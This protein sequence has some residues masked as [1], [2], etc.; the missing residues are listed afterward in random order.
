MDKT[1]PVPKRHYS[2]A[3]IVYRQL[4]AYF[5]EKMFHVGDRVPPERALADA[6]KANR[7][8][9]RTAMQRM[10][11]EGIVTRHVGRGT[12]FTALPVARLRHM[13]LGQSSSPQDLLELRQLIE[14]GIAALAAQ[15]LPAELRT[16]LQRYEAA[17]AGLVPGGWLE[18]DL[19]LLDILTESTGNAAILQLV[20][21]VAA[22]RRSQDNALPSFMDMQRWRKHQLGIVQAVQAQDHE[23]A[24]ARAFA[25]LT[26]K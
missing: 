5:A 25:K 18:A 13:P 22:L 4:E 26:E 2:S 6:L 21:L 20:A 16:R 19:Q 10:V 24:R 11:R 23:T 17:L 12:F 8:T 1:K 9:L 7:T 3:D 15:R 14:P